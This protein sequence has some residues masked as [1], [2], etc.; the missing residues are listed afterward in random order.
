M[1]LEAVSGRDPHSAAEERLLLACGRV[2]DGARSIAEAHRFGVPPGRHRRLWTEEYLREAVRV[3]GETLPLW[4][5]RAVAA[6]FR[7]SADAMAAR[8]IPAP[9]AE[10]WHIVGTYMRNASAA[11]MAQVASRGEDLR[12]PDCAESLELGERM[13]MVVRFDRVAALAAREGALRLERA[14]VA[15]QRHLAESSS[16]VLDDAQRRLL[17]RVAE[18]AAI[19]ELADEFGYSRRTVH[20]EL[21]RLWE[22][23]G[24][25]DRVQ[26]MCK[27]AAEGLLD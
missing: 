8:S 18:G 3:Y 4:Y 14:A 5:Q 27:A 1:P 11:V 2:G 7:E 19:A 23:L 20:R 26:A 10:D 16:L 12:P 17:Q 21:A 15:V 25:H 24:V 13:P 22:A 9:L 6:L